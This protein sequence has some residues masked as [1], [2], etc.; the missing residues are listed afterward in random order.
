VKENLVIIGGVAAGLAAAMQARRR[1][2]ELNITVLEKTQDISYGACGMPYVISGAIQSFEKLIVHSPEYFQE[3]HNIE[4][5]LGCEAL[6][7]FP[8]K[9]LILVKDN[10]T[11]KEIGYNNLVLSTGAAV[12]CPPI[13][14]NDLDGIHVLRH[15]IHGRKL[16]DDLERNRPRKAVI[17]GAGY[18]GLELAEAFRARGLQTTI[19]EASDKVMR[20]IDGALRDV[21][22]D[23]LKRNGVEIIFGERVAAFE[24]RNGRISR[25]I[26]ANN[27]VIEK[28]V[29]CVGVGVHA[30]SELAKRA[31]LEIGANGA[32]VTDAYQRTS[33]AN[34]YAA[35]DC[36]EIINRVSGKRVW[37]PLGQPAIK[38]GWVAGTNACGVG[39][40]EKYAGVVGT[41]IVKVFDLEL[42]R[43]GLGIDEAREYGFDVDVIENESYSRAGYYPNGTK[44]LTRI[45][46]DRRGKLL[47]AQ[48]VGREGVAQRIDVYAAALHASLKIEDIENFD[49]AYAPPFAPTIDPIQRAA[50]DASKKRG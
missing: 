50:H 7:I 37:F 4:I 41:N 40:S 11:Q 17:V 28:D 16:L 19:I 32:I 47:G 8:A 23:E 39:T 14:G 43:T 42:A 48:M 3:K 34:I 29:A 38:Q 24:G 25:V 9:S 18:I 26:T 21:V 44:I 22:A 20:T 31:R 15:I 2:P 49:L 33:T 30:N 12:V 27:L 5:K 10:G 46:F 13:D 1:S 6:E 36:C 35:G 45:I